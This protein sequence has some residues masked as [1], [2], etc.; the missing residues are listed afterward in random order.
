MRAGESGGFAG[1]FAPAVGSA[2]TDFDVDVGAGLDQMPLTK[3]QG[4]WWRWGKGLLGSRQMAR[5]PA[6]SARVAL[7]GRVKVM[8]GVTGEGDSDGEFRSRFIHACLRGSGF[9][10]GLLLDISWDRDLAFVS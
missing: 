4:G 8:Y 5:G 6:A 1:S 10:G 2:E 7:M 3:V 9:S